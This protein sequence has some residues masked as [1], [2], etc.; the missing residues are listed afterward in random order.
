RVSGGQWGSFKLGKT[1]PNYS[2]QGLHSLVAIY[3]A[4]SGHQPI[5][6]RDVADPAI[7]DKVHAIEMATI[8]YGETVTNYLC[9]LAAIDAADPVRALTYVSAIAMEE[10]SVFDFNQGRQSQCPG[11][12]PHFTLV[13]VYPED[14][15]IM[16]DSPYAILGN[17]N[18]DQVNLANDFL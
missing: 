9:R 1:N 12:S 5:V 3:S 13:A 6:A 18:P 8:H 11:T 4:F 15:T 10:K 2:T 16:T 17:A 14:G 7:R